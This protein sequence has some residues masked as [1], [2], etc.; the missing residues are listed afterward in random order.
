[1]DLLTR[2]CLARFLAIGFMILMNGASESQAQERLR[3]FST[4]AH[5]LGYQ[6]ARPEDDSL[7]SERPTFTPNSTSL[8][9]N[10]F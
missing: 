2:Q 8:G 4:L 6:Q 5:W 3:D 7:N 9:R 10:V 1:M